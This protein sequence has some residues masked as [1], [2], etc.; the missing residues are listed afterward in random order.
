MA[1]IKGWKEVDPMEAYEKAYIEKKKFKIHY[2]YKMSVDKKNSKIVLKELGRNPTKYILKRVLVERQQHRVKKM[3]KTT[4]KNFKNINLF[5]GKVETKGNFFIFFIF[6]YFYFFIFYFF[7]FLFFIF[8][9]F[10]FFYIFYFLF[11]FLVSRKNFDVPGSRVFVLDNFLSKEEC[12]HYIKETERVGF[13]DLVNEF[14]K[15][16]RSNDRT[17]V[18]S[19]EL[20]EN[21]WER[22]KVCLKEDD[23]VFIRYFLILI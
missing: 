14:D 5:E 18:L 16:Y 23:I 17:L 2:E 11:T 19:D 15:K 22:M 3:L 4:S 9:F 8:I 10:Y 6:L 12:E 7:I 21:L 20:A 1:S 13:D